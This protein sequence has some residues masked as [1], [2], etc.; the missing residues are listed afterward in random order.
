MCPFGD[1]TSLRAILEFHGGLT[2]IIWLIFVENLTQIM[3]S[4][5]AKKTPNDW[6]K[7]GLDNQNNEQIKNI[8][9][10]AIAG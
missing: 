9:F 2:Q 7:K 10:S 3:S 4:N 1:L 5:D 8:F 6:M